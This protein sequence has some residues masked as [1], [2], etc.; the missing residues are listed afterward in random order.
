MKYSSQ[1][2]CTVRK[3]HYLGYKND[4]LQSLDIR[5]GTNLMLLDLS[6]AFDTI[7]RDKNT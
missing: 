7:D 6:A 1:L 2:S 5:G 3:Q 4:I